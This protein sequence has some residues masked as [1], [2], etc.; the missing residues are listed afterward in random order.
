MKHTH[1]ST[2]VLFVLQELGEYDGGVPYCQPAAHRERTEYMVSEWRCMQHP[3]LGWLVRI[4]LQSAAV[5]LTCD[6]CLARRQDHVLP[7]ARIAQD[8]AV[9]A[10][11]Y[12][13]SLLGN[14]R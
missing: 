7:M 8:A 11:R 10:G 13:R 3:A 1:S 5:S 4:R 9:E 2:A 6:R 12:C 14:H